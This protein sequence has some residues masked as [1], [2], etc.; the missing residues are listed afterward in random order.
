MTDGSGN[1][2]FNGVS[3]VVQVR[4]TKDGY[5]PETQSVTQDTEH[6]NVELTPTVP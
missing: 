3:G 2:A 1:Y 4:A 6:V 5:Q